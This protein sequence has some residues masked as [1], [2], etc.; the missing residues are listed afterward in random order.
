[1]FQV[2]DLCCVQYFRKSSH[3]PLAPWHYKKVNVQIHFATTDEKEHLM[4]CAVDILRVVNE[5]HSSQLARNPVQFDDIRSHLPSLGCQK[6]RYSV[7]LTGT[8]ITVQVIHMKLSTLMLA[9]CTF[10]KQISHSL[11]LISF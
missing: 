1:M 3:L 11:K 7:S 10:P 5:M 6:K 9:T 8:F 4:P 2:G